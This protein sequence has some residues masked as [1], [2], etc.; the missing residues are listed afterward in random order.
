MNRNRPRKR[1]SPLLP[2]RWV[3]ARANCAIFSCCRD[4]PLVQQ[5]T[6]LGIGAGLFV[7]RLSPEKYQL[8]PLDPQVYARN[9]TCRSIRVRWTEV[10]ISVESRM[11]ISL[12]A[13]PGFRHGLQQSYYLWKSFVL[14][15]FSAPRPIARFWPLACTL[16]APVAETKVPLLCGA[17]TGRF[18]H[19]TSG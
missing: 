6:I 10:W 3:R 8:I 11:G 18:E 17:E 2:F 13:T 14:S 12:L 19:R 9:P 4:F 5:A 16:I 15:K 7:L 1:T